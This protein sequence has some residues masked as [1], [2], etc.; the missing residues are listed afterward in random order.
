[1]I[2]RADQGL[3]VAKKDGRNRTVLTPVAQTR[4]IRAA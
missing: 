3:Y 2:E 4:A 1:M